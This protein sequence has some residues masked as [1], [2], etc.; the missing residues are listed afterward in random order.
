MLM[1]EMLK[2][3]VDWYIGLA[4]IISRYLGFIGVG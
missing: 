1:D 4:D 3:K 2:V